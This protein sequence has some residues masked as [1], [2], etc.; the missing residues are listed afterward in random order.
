MNEFYEKQYAP[1]VGGKIVGI[2]TDDDVESHQTYVGLFIDMGN[3][4]EY[5]LWC[6]SDAEGNGAGYL[7]LR[8][9]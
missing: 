8:E 1:I 6:L 3:G 4:R 5:T 9:V 2:L 7:E